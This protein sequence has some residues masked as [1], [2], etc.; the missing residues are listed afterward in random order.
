MLFSLLSLSASEVTLGCYQNKDWGC[1]GGLSGSACLVWV[2][3]IVYIIGE[4]Q[5]IL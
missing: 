5:Y 2:L 1:V 4:L 3:S